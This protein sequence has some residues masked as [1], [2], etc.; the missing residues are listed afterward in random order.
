MPF[1]E[2]AAMAK[3]ATHRAEARTREQAFPDEK[4][5]DTH[6]GNLMI[7]SPSTDRTTVRGF[8]HALLLGLAVTALVA[9]GGGDGAHSD[10]AANPAG[11]DIGAGVERVSATAVPAPGDVLSYSLLSA[12][13]TLADAVKQYTFTYRSTDGV[14]G[15]GLVTTSGTIFYPKGTAPAGGWPVIA[16]GHGTVGIGDNCAPS[17]NLR[18]ARDAEYLNRWLR[19]GYVV[20]ATD[21]QGLGTPGQHFYLHAR[22]ESYALLDSVRALLKWPYVSNQVVLVGQA[23]GAHAVFAADS[24]AA[25]YAPELNIRGAVA[26]STPHILRANAAQYGADEVNPNLYS[27]FYLAKGA[28]M[29]DPSLTDTTIFSSQAL[30]AAAAASEACVG[31]LWTS[32]IQAGLTANNTFAQPDG[33]ARLNAAVRESLRYPSFTL[34]RPIFMGIG[35]QDRAVST[36]Q[37]V[38]LATDACK[39]GSAVT[40]KVYADKDQDSAL[41]ASFA[42]ALAFVR[43]LSS[44]QAPGSTCASLVAAPA[45]PAAGDV[46]SSAP[47][48]ATQS[49]ADAGEQY[50]ITYLSTDGMAGTGLLSATGS[51]FYP[52]GTPPAGGWPL[53]VWGHG[54]AGIADVCAP[55]RNARSARDA[56]YLNRWL[57]EGYAVVAPDYQGLGSPGFH[58]YLHARAES[59]SLLD[60]ARAALKMPNVSNRIMLVGQ[61]QGGNAVFAAAG[62]AAAYAP[63]LNVRGTVATGTPHLMRTAN[64]PQFGPDEVNP[65]LYSRFYLAKAAQYLDPALT[66]EMLF[67]ARA[68]PLYANAGEM[69]T[70]QL[71]GAVINAGLT[72]NN[73]YADASSA[74]RINSTIR[75]SLRYPTLNFPRPIFMGIGALDRSVSGEQQVALATDACSAGSN[76]VHRVYGDKDHDG[77][78]NASFA[79]AFAFTQQVMGNGVP[80]STCASLGVVR[81]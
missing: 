74:Q 30:P 19:E 25:S 70:N 39:A 57:R 43:Q 65:N 62:Y 53:V 41:N 75:E 59:Y 27:K 31:S 15:T 69:C 35:G 49:L 7:S 4:H 51:I 6:Q 11:T 55:S 42:D 29:L 21:Y 50:S 16:W 45:E 20:V 68:L 78:L 24:I 81:P 40:H 5:T 33:Q 44:G 80:A 58:F 17:R 48:T 10:T 26:T 47:L 73:V 22:A 13:Q 1:L 18:S 8:C 34:P 52:R 9:C 60:S 76:V 23:Q 77:A 14:S 66:N 63:D 64:V 28:Q 36:E 54:T 2:L 79:D 32:V 61:S 38:A 46:V 12:D 3:V 72:A 67:S 71:Y 56:E 37:Q